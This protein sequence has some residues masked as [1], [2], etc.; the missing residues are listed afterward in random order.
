VKLWKVGSTWHF[1]FQVGGVRVQKSTGTSVKGQAE[2]I[3][4]NALQDAKTRAK[5]QTPMPTLGK[6]RDEWLEVHAATASAG[7]SR[8]VH[9]WNL[10]G[11]GDVKLD[12]L[13]TELVEVARAAHAE[14]RSAETANGWMRVLNLLVHWAVRREVI[15]AL[16]YRVKMLKVQR[17][18][19]PVL[20]LSVVK[21]WLESVDATARNSQVG[22]AVRLMIGLGLRES[23]AL[24]ARWEWIDWDSKTYTP[25]KTKGKEAVPV[26]CPAWLLDH[27]EALKGD[28]P[29][30]GLIL[31]WKT[32]E[33]GTET[34][35]PSNFARRAIAAA[36]KDAGTP[37][38]S[39]H[40]I[41]GTWITHHLRAGVPLPEVQKM[42]RHKSKQTTLG[43][44]EESR[45]VQ[46]AAQD[47]LAQKMGLA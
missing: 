34:P 12:R 7:H 44:Y 22:T 40:R 43:Y 37:G 39:A 20:P 21:A 19:R 35:H 47:D 46:K 31:P 8:N 38:V 27:L 9:T 33:D 30:L 32:L 4:L 18:P 10:H 45:E 5:G 36:N 6:L 23:E 26:D 42:A 1:R 41:R 24:G 15:P 13:S 16:P 11:L 29:R 28:G 3:A 2:T 14:G 25:G 17:R